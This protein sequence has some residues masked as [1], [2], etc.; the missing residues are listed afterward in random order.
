MLRVDSIGQ[1]EVLAANW[2]FRGK[3]IKHCSLQIKIA[4]IKSPFKTGFLLLHFGE[5]FFCSLNGKLD[6]FIRMSR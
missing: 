6:I 3:G 5:G 2:I 1:F 4:Q